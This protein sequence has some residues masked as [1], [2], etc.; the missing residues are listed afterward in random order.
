[1]ISI[2]TDVEQLFSTDED[3]EDKEDSNKGR[4]A[5]IMDGSTGKQSY[6]KWRRRTLHP[7]YIPKQMCTE[8]L[9]VSTHPLVHGLAQPIAPVYTVRGLQFI[10]SGLLPATVI[11]N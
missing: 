8:E 7:T 9:L 2:E 11:P 10:A 5:L 4:A 3:E 6:S 1:M